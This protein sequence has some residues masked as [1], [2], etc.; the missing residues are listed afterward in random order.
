MSFREAG[1]MLC[2]T[3]IASTVW[4]VTLLWHVTFSLRHV[5]FSLRRVTFS[6]QHVTFSLRHVTFSLQ[7]VTFSLWHVTFSL[8]HVSFIYRARNAAI[9]GQAYPRCLLPGQL[10]S[11]QNQLCAPGMGQQCFGVTDVSLE[12]PF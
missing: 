11:R 7:H 8:R 1:L 3:F 12:G 10:H 2:C 6:L 4:H 5:T 9:M